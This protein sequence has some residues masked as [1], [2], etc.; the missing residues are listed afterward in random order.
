MGK[1]REKLERASKGL[2]VVIVLW[3]CLSRAH[4][5]AHRCLFVVTMDHGDDDNERV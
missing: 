2:K 5:A 4:D 3:I 1:V